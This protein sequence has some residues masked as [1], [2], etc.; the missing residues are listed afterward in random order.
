MA[1]T[2]SRLSIFFLISVINLLKGVNIRKILI[3][4]SADKTNQMFINKL[5]LFNCNWKNTYNGI[6]DQGKTAIVSKTDSS[7]FTKVKRSRSIAFSVLT[8]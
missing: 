7:T 2:T 6:N 3:N 5:P 1:T 8:V 4:R